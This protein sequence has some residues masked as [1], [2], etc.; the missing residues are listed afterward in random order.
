MH[1][2]NFFVAAVEFVTVVVLVAATTMNYYF[3]VLEATVDLRSADP[4]R[5]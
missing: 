5:Q 2:V 3:L 1:F 4:E